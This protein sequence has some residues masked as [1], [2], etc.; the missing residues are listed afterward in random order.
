MNTIFFSQTFRALPRHPGKILGEFFLAFVG[1]S[2]GKLGGSLAGIFFG[3]TKHRHPIFFFQ[4]NFGAFLGDKSSTQTLF[5]KHFGHFRDIP[6]NPGISRQK[7]LISLASR[8]TSNFLAPT[9]S[10]GRPL[11]HRKISGL[12]SLGLC[13]FF[14]AS[15]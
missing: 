14:R 6:A 11:P 4:G 8:D 15:K 3:P 13:S 1:K 7:S 2:C 9:P 5:L 10:R 12:K